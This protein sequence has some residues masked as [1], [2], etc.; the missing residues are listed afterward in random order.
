MAVA[1]FIRIYDFF[2][3]IFALTVGWNKLFTVPWSIIALLGG[4]LVVR[5]AVKS[6]ET[7][8]GVDMM[9]ER[10]HYA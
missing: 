7:G 10:Y 6:K 2:R 9:L 3:T 1:L 5:L 8:Y 4:Y